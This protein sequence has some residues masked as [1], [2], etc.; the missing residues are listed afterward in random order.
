ML[1]SLELNQWCLLTESSQS[2]AM[3]DI[4]EAMTE[5]PPEQR[6]PDFLTHGR[7]WATPSR[8]QHCSPSHGSGM[9]AASVA[10]VVLVAGQQRQ[11]SSPVLLFPPYYPIAPYLCVSN[12]RT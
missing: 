5:G 8:C 6:T 1:W 9:R 2:Y 12:T 11:R 3:T 10:A 7:P 4:S